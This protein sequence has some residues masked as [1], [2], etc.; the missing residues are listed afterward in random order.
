LQDA[1][2]SFLDPK[3][4]QAM[5]P[6]IIIRYPKDSYGEENNAM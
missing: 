3:N 4:I 5:G 2:V 6:D 1:K